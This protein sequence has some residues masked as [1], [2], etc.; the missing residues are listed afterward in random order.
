ML[1]IMWKTVLE[2]WNL[3]LCDGLSVQSRSSVL[4][5]VLIVLII[6]LFLFFSILNTLYVHQQKTS[7]LRITIHFASATETWETDQWSGL[8]TL[9]SLRKYLFLSYLSIIDCFIW[10]NLF[11]CYIFFCFCFCYFRIVEF[12]WGLLVI[13]DGWNK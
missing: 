2:S 3:W 12:I 9:D 6:F 8:W 11:C 5:I 1:V 4:V 7:D 10:C 13:T